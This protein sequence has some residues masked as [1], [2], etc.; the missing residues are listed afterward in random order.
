MKYIVQGHTDSKCQVKVQ[1][2][3]IAKTMC[4]T[5]MPHRS[6][7]DCGSGLGIMHLE[8]VQGIN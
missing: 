2:S 4:F 5:T 6:Q 3:R 7:L 1:I 8:C